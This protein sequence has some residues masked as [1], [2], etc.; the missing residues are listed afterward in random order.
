VSMLRQTL[1]LRTSAGALVSPCAPDRSEPRQLIQAAYNLSLQ[2]QGP[3]AGYAFYYSIAGL[4]GHESDAAPG[5]GA[6]ISRRR[7]RIQTGAG[8]RHDLAVG[9]AGGGFADSFAEFAVD[10]SSRV[11]R[12][13]ARR[14]GFRPRSII[15]QSTIEGTTIRHRSEHDCVLSLRGKR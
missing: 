8:G 9:V 11:N 7:T 6:G 10:D 14:R 5:R 1:V 3:I 15:V 12:S 4:A 13:P 2:Q